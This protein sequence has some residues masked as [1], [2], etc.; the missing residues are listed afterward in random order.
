VLLTTQYLDEA[1]L[2]ADRVAV[3]RSGRIVEEGTPKQ[4]KSR[5]G[6]EVVE[7]RGA[8]DALLT[9]IGTDGTIRGLRAAI[10]NLETEFPG[11]TVSL[12]KPSLDDVFLALTAPEDSFIAPELIST[13]G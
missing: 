3:L 2:L 8:D 10:E 9:E 13:K 7:V 6:G 4:L 11:A 5:T 1:D 12:R